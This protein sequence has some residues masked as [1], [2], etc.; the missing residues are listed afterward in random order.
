MDINKVV[1]EIKLELNDVK[2]AGHEPA[3]IVLHP[4]CIRQLKRFKPEGYERPT[5]PDAREGKLFGVPVGM[6]PK[7]NLYE[8]LI[9]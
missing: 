2:N 4:L 6:D 7:K 9:K 8:I 5:S 3:L 1:N